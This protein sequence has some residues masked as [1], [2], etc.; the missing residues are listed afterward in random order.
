MTGDTRKVSS[1]ADASSGEAGGRVITWFRNL[2]TKID[3]SKPISVPKL[4]GLVLG[5]VLL[6]SIQM[7]ELPLEPAQQ[8][9]L[10]LLLMTITFWVF[11]VFP[12]ALTAVMALALA[13]VL[14]VAEPKETFGAFSSPTLFLLLGSFIITEAMIRHGL[15][16]RVA[17][18]VLSI[19]GIASSTHRIIIVFGALAA[20]LSTVLD[21]GAVAAILLPMAVS[22]SKTFADEIDDHGNGLPSG[23]SSNFTIALL[24]ITAYGSTVGA[25]LT[26]LGDA[27][28]LVGWEF[29]QAASGHTVPIGA[30]VAIAAPIVVV[31]FA[32]L[33]AVVLMINRPEISTIPGALQQVREKR[34]AL[35]PMSQGEINTCIV[36]T[37]AVLFWLAP[38]I[39]AAVSGHD[40]TL[41]AFL[42]DRFPPSVV[43]ILAAAL[44][45]LMP[46]GWHK[47]FTL[48]WKDVT[49]TNWGPILIVG[50]TLALGGLLGSTGLAQVLGEA[51]AERAS[52]LNA[53]GVYMF[54][55]AAALGFSELTTNLVSVT[56]LVPIIPTL[57]TSGGGDPLQAAL[58][59]TFAAIYG[60][61]LPISTSANA[62]IYGSGK[63]P[64][65]R[66]VKTGFLV[67]ISG[68]ILVVTGVHVM[69]KFVDFF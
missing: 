65:W 8:S 30:W 1:S 47:G 19:P 7:A 34:K 57:A 62:I 4:A 13:V 24:L 68:I 39:V 49:N 35:G 18:S 69:L 20:L 31:L 50:A 27:S 6:M 60:F 15:G 54:S 59:A 44:L 25:L 61:M 66:M 37:L 11:Q 64:F 5:P 46:I 9:L 58:I 41:Y 32:V 67:D 43:A 28:N 21:N 29:I 36:F 38:S 23:R 33:A 3:E 22:L 45:F 51:L 10:G 55:A 14:N 16:K 2:F 17:L 12:I 56:V 53:L 63:V 48:K 40:A 26:P 52:G 42:N